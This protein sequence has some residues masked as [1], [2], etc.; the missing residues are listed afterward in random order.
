MP[1]AAA[2]SAGVNWPSFRGPLASGIADRF[3]TP[4]R[5]NPETGQNIRWK[6]AI[7]GLGHSSPVIWNRRLFVSSAVREQGEPDLKVG[8]Y[9]DI[10][11]V[12][13]Q[14]E[15]RW[16]V[17]CLDKETGEILWQQTA[18]KGVPTI[19]RHPKSSH[20]NSTL[21]TDG[22]YVVSFFGSEGLFCF[23]M[24]GALVWRKDLG[25][26]DSGFFMA[27][28][29]QWGFGSSPVIHQNMVIVQCDVQTNSFLA[30]FNLKDGA[31]LWRAPRKDVP[32]WST[33]TVHARGEHA[34]VI[35]NGFQ[36]IGGYDLATGREIWRLSG[37][38]DIPVPT[39]VVAGEL[40]FITSAHG[41]LAPIYAVKL[42]AQGDISLRT[43]QSAN[44]HIPWSMSRRGNYM[45][46]PLV[47]GDFLYCCS[48]AGVLSCYRISTGERLYSERLGTGGSGFTASGVAADGKLYFTSEPGDVYVVKAGPEFTLLAR[49]ELGEMCLA[50]PAISEGSLFFRA[51]QHLIAIGER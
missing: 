42:S 31:E 50:S 32:T 12:I 4:E 49:N 43:N 7:P 44:E 51:R 33:P 30:A 28:T 11:S 39:P 15:H 9:G 10:G 24:D 14:T 38:G 16:E 8:L 47:Y 22:R 40:V 3:T 35:V 6:T 26:L 20:A 25:R 13:E 5:W 27:P 29:A 48:D 34:Q 37:G 18:H 41:K 23:D 46:T 21:A 19:K 36:H 2:E 1:C 45:Q 17:F